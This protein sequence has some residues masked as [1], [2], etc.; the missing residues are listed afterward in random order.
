MN[1]YQIYF[2]TKINGHVT[3]EPIG[4]I[5]YHKDR[6]LEKLE[7]LNGQKKPINTEYIYEMVVV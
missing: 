7:V 4:C 5:M 1:K 6:V 2:V 3:K